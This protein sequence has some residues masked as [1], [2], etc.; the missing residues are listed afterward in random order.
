MN[1]SGAGISPQ[2]NQELKCFPCQTGFCAQPKRDEM[3]KNHLN[4]TWVQVKKNW[5]LGLGTIQQDPHTCHLIKTASI[6]FSLNILNNWL[7]L[8]LSIHSVLFLFHRELLC[9][10]LQSQEKLSH[11]DVFALWVCRLSNSFIPVFSIPMC[12]PCC[13]ILSKQTN[14]WSCITLKCASFP[15]WLGSGWKL[16]KN[17]Y[18]TSYQYQ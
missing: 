17:A 3:V 9:M 2:N 13:F 7:L 15:A 5:D 1:T 16:K 6:L 4:G 8:Q 10:H 11:S 18:I 12:F 14:V